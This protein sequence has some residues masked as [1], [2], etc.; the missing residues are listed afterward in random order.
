MNFYLSDRIVGFRRSCFVYNLGVKLWKLTAIPYFSAVGYNSP[1][2]ALFPHLTTR[3]AM[4][5]AASSVVWVKCGALFWP[6]KVLDID[7]DLDPEIRDEIK[8]EKKQPKYVV[9]FFDEEG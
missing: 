1:R 3:T 7:T 4:P 5:F 2:F 6:A 8:D 9:K